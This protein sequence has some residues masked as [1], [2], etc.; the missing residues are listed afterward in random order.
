MRLFVAIELPEHIRLHL[1]RMQE[2]L[3]PIF[4]GK[5]TRPE[6]LHVTLK[7][8]GETPD[9]QLPDLIDA[10]TEV[11]MDMQILLQIKGII[12]LPPHGPA[13]IVAAGFED[14]GGAAMALA[15]RIDTACL[16]V[17]YRLEGRVWTPHV[18]LAR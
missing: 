12:Y 1:V 3:R 18:T 13:R 16:E 11:E 17:G 5:W 9:E 14:V 10:L 8:L 6:Q 4:G 15:E 7:F 2:A